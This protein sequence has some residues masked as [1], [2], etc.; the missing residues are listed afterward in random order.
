[1]SLIPPNVAVTKMSLVSPTARSFCDIRSLL[2][3]L[4]QN[5]QSAPIREA[6]EQIQQGIDQIQ[7]ALRGSQPLISQMAAPVSL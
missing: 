1:M 4:P 2:S 3:Q 5:A 7:A 6:L